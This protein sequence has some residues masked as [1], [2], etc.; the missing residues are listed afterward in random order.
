MSAK[1]NYPLIQDTNTTRTRTTITPGP[2]GDDS[3]A[4]LLIESSLSTSDGTTLK[5]LFGR[6]PIYNITNESYRVAATN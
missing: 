2:S 1:I 5:K 4:T 6:S 3:V